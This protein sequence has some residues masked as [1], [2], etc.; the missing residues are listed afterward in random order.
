LADGAARGRSAS[1]EAGELTSHERAELERL[2]AEVADLR[3]RPATPRRRRPSW[4]TPV[5]S[6]LIVVGC[7]FAPL[8]M[9]AVWSANQISNTDRYVAN[10]APLIKEPAV[11]HALTDKISN[12]INAKLNV[13][14]VAGQ[15]ATLLSQRGL[16]RVGS[17]LNTFSGALAGAV[18]G[19]IHGQVAKIVASPAVGP[20]VGAAQPDRP[21]ARAAL[22]PRE[23]GGPAMSSSRP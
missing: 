14:E 10:V 23:V 13:K 5:A 12:E 11:Q 8:S 3:A 20:A 17:I 1:R 18:A 15:A 9:V 19:F 7:L 22:T 16:T 2:R 6:L 21:D 4:R